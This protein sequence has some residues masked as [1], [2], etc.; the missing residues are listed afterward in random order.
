MEQNIMKEDKELK[1]MHTATEDA[2]GI[3]KEIETLADEI[4]E[5]KK[6][7]NILSV[8]KV[9]AMGKKLREAKSKVS[10]GEWGSWLKQKVQFT[11][12]TAD[13]YMKIAVV[14]GEGKWKS[15]SNLGVTKLGMLIEIPDEKRDAYIENHDLTQ[16]S[17]RDLAREIK[18]MNGDPR[19]KGNRQGKDKML[20]TMKSLK[21]KVKQMTDESQNASW[22]ED[23]I[24]NM[25]SEELKTVNTSISVLDEWI[26]SVK[27]CMDNK[28]IASNQ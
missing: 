12:R 20:A 11:Q 4:L 28:E 2:N 5:L 22:I 15:L 10:H 27:K 17:T 7:L 23:N 19:N 13:K 1:S 6:E 26:K 21:D 24:K 3:D 25:S 18:Q 14:F 8:D 16:M 9:I